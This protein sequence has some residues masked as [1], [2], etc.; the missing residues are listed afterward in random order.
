MWICIVPRREHNSKLITYG[1]RCQGISQ[2]YLHTPLSS[3][4]G[5]KHICLC[6]PSWSWCSF[7]D[8]GG[9]EGWV[10]MCS[11]AA[12][13]SKFVPLSAMWAVV[14]WLRILQYCEFKS[15]HVLW[16]NHVVVAPATMQ[17]SISYCWHAVYLTKCDNICMLIT[18]IQVT[19]LW[20]KLTTIDYTFTHLH[21]FCEPLEIYGQISKKNFLSL[22]A[23]CDFW[24]ATP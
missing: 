22:L 24:Y 16:Q 18:R 5:M 21:H 10:G 14:L 13:A 20:G 19:D 15:S 9:M 7:T 12:S 6:L 8:P 4:S 17:M 23:L 3:A 2:F 1:P 11:V